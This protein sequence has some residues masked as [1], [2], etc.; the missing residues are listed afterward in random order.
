MSISFSNSVK[1]MDQKS[2]HEID[3]IVM[4]IAFQIHNEIGRLLDEKIYQQALLHR[5]TS[6]GLNC[7]LE[8]EIQLIH[9]EF[10]KSY[11]IDLV[12]NGVIFETKT[13]AQLN[14]Q[15]EAQVLNYLLLT[16]SQHGKL[17][18]LRTSSVESRFVSTTL[19]KSDRTKFNIQATNSTIGQIL[20]DLLSEIGTHLS[21][22]LYKDAVQILLNAKSHQIRLNDGNTFIGAQTMSMLTPTKALIVTGIPAEQG[23]L[24]YQKHLKRLLLSAELESFNWINFNNR[25]ITQSELTL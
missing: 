14:P 25:K 8:S 17:I 13:C 18:N 12:V 9:K 6:A 1:V 2:F 19:T 24:P 21:I 15:H 20:H 4:G 22:N 5:L 7:E 3:R 23:I 16:N 11:F 10:N